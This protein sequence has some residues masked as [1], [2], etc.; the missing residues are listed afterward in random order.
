M[1]KSSNSQPIVE[2]KDV[3]F[4][5]GQDAARALDH[6]SLAVSEGEFVGI[7]GPSGAGKSTLAAVMSGAIPH[8][9]T[10]QLFG[11]TYVDGHDTC[12]VTLT[13]I[14]RVVG[15][16][17]QDIDSQMVASVVEDEMLFG[18]EN[19]GVPHDQIEERIS[20]A[21]GTVGIS[22]LRDREIAKLSGGQKQ[23]VAIAAILAL[24]PRVLVLDE[25]TAALDPA[26]STLVFE[27]LR[28]V[29]Q[30]AGITVVVIEQKVALLCKYCERVVVLSEGKLAF[31]G[32]PHEVFGHARELRAMGVDTP[33]VARIANSL[34]EHGVVEKIDRPC[35]NVS[36]A[37]ELISGLVGGAAQASAAA[38]GARNTAAGGE[39][40][41]QPGRTP[42]VLIPDAVKPTRP[43]RHKP[44]TRPHAE[45]TEP[46]VEVDGVS[47]AYP[48]RGDS[49]SDLNMRVY[50][51]ELVGIIG[52]NGAGKTT[53]TKL[54]NGLFK[55]KSGTVRIAGLDTREVPTSVIAARC[56]TLFQNPDRQICKDTVLEEVAFGLTLHGTPQDEAERRAAEVIA[57]FDLPA[58]ESPFSLSRGQRQ[59]VALASVVVLDPQVVLLDE[60]TSGLDYRECMTVM[61][62]VREMAERGCAVIMVCHD[63]EVVSDFAERIVVMTKGRI[64]ARDEADAVFADDE[65]MAAAYV[66]PPQVIAL[67]KELAADVSPE[68]AGISQ[69]S[70]IV[71][72]VEEMVNRG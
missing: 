26:S 23:K 17:L 2:L 42:S 9:Y 38:E 19:Y 24:A 44:A 14:S 7:I 1:S 60:P 53:F 35:L 48:N 64:V 5:Y 30:V 49:V 11:A 15:S 57:R 22:H 59:M 71:D 13:D 21:L 34:L 65:L 33:R 61:E 46:V 69:V 45:G 20:R 62:T 32:E 37:K 18:L 56:A 52:Q 43:S 3:S 55:P 4:A 8:H 6:V 10:G 39:R 31:D 16:V 27:T 25:P 68:F 36:E 58:S 63:M 41:P 40:P 54:L 67:S 50:P 47:F 29:N 28:Q 66:E 51:G 72:L 70:G 12:E